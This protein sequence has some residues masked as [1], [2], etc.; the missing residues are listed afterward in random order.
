MARR[1][2]TNKSTSPKVARQASAA[3]RDRRTSKRTRSIAG[4]ALAQ[5]RAKRGR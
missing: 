4:S 2:S 3:L 5:A 1:L